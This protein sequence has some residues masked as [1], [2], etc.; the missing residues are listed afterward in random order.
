MRISRI[1]NGEARP[2]DIKIVVIMETFSPEAVLQ[3]GSSVD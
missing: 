1:D 3:S 2:D